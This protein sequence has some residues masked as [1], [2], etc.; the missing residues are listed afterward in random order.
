[1]GRHSSATRIVPIGI[2]LFLLILTNW[3]KKAEAAPTS[4]TFAAA[5]DLSVNSRTSTSLDLVA[6]SGANFALALG[7]LSYSQLTPESAWCDYVKS[8]VSTN[9]PFELLSG[10]HEDNGPDGLIENF[11]A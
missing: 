6:T 1:M 3:G 4:F 10:N 5:G 9:F 2:L 8:H 11:T 7:D